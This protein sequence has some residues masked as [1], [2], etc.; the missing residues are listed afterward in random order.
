MT[1]LFQ[2]THTFQIKKKNVNLG[3]S[4]GKITRFV[5]NSYLLTVFFCQFT[6]TVGISY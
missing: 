4:D 3:Y 5:F 1:K 6:C 2:V